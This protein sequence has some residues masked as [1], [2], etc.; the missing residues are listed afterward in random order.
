MKFRAA[1]A[2][3]LVMAAAA[4]TVTER[5][6]P[7][8]AQARS[9]AVPSASTG[10]ADD[11]SPIAAGDWSYARAAHLIERAGFGATPDEIARLAAMTPQQAV[12]GLVDYES[13]DE[14]PE[15]VR[16]V[17]HLGSRAWI[18]SRR[19]APKRCAWRANAA[20]VW[21]RRCCR[22]GAQRRLQ[23][24]VD[25]FFYSLDANAIETQ[26][27]GLWWANRMLDDQRPLE[28]KLTLFWHGHFATGEN[29]VRDYRMMLRQNEMFRAH[30]SGSFRDLLVGILKDPAML[31]YLDNGENVKTHP[32]E[33]FGRELLELF[34]MGV[35]NYTE[36]DVREAARAF[37]GWTN[38]VLVFKFDARP[39]RLRPE[40]V[41]R[42]GRDRSTAR[43]SSTSSSR[44]RSP[45]SSSPRSSTGSS[46]ARRSPTPSKAELGRTFRDSGYQMKPLLKRIFLSK[47]FYSP[48]SVATQIKSPG[49]P[50]R[51]DLQEVGARR[52]ADDS[53]LRPD[54][55]EPGAVAVRSAERRR[56]GRRPHLDHAVDAAPARATC[57]AA[58]SFP[59]SRASAPP[60]RVDVRHRRAGRAAARSRA[61]ASRKPPGKTT[62]STTMAESNMMVDRDEDYNTRYGGYKGCL[63]A[64]ERTKLIPRR[65]ATIDL[66]AMISGRRCATQS[67]RSSITSLAG[68][69]RCRLRTRSAP[70]WSISCAASS[71]RRASS[72]A[73]ARGLAPRAAVSGVEHAGVS[74]GIGEARSRSG[75]NRLEGA[76]EMPRK[77]MPVSSACSRRDFLARGLYGIG[78]GAGLPLVLS[79]TS[80]ALAAQ[81]LEGTSVEKHPE[82]ILVVIELSGGN[83]GLNTVV[84][85][86]RSRVL[87]RADR[88]SA[89]PEREVLIKAADGFGFH[90]VD[91]R[92][93]AAL[94]GRH[95]GRGPWLRVR[96]SEPVA[97]LVDGVL[98][99]R[100]AQRAASRSDG[101]A[102]WRIDATMPSTRNVIVNLGNSQSLAVR[103]RQHSPLVF[104]DPARFRR[105]GTDAEKQALAALSQPRATANSTLEFLASTAQNADRE[106]GLRAPGVG[107]AIARPWTT[108]L[109]GGLGGNL[110]RVAAL[111]AAGM[112]TR[113]Y[114]VTYSGNSFDTHVQQ[115]DL[116]SRLLMYTADAV[117]GFIDDLER[118]GPGRRGRGDDLHRVRPP[119][120][121][122]RQPR[123]RSRHGDADV[124]R[125]QGRQGRLLRAASEPHRSRRRQHEDDDRFS[126]RLRDDD[127]GVARLRR[128]AERS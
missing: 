89:S 104:D 44:S 56:L 99:H 112:P 92:L 55:G 74:V 46:C 38:D 81:A 61:W 63:L 27:L 59:T 103:S 107:A 22:E 125:R 120:R 77:R 114:Y 82:R 128:H 64:F 58:C 34:T 85:Y 96:P 126:A 3:A 13:I 14:R 37:T 43:T 87:S 8:L 47:D 41:S 102:G 117:R 6:L 91:G 60:D 57:S 118:I 35:G 42:A 80:A 7:A 31:V 30:A 86:R 98:A 100:R 19:A 113:L 39:A 116:H 28:E 97:F 9:T 16:R 93:R 84:P 65:P 11:L 26:R 52:G 115:A 95:A 10:W 123:H 110:Q 17:G 94:Q 124:R 127:Q 15:A 2:V 111:I 12:D 32:N 50:R 73:R 25:K 68:S 53:R 69:C 48:P 88:S 18:R 36:R 23:P 109:G 70:C 49:A 121:R 29:K 106:L 71:G 51:V 122:E 79:R 24:V 75:L 67:T 33:N 1:F 62:T 45:P 119:R 83:D 101:W 66:T 76:F 5:T 108:G 105:E 72:R 20:R 78:V 21:A 90:P 40:D 54:D 4:L